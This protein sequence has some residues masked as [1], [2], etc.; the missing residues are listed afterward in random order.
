M[1]VEAPP[2]SEGG[3]ARPTR[4]VVQVPP[5]LSPGS[6]FTAEVGGQLM[7]VKVPL[8]APARTE[9]DLATGAP[10][11]SAPGHA[12]AR[13]GSARRAR[14]LRG[15]SKARC[16]SSPSEAGVESS[17]DLESSMLSSDALAS[18][19]TGSRLHSLR[20]GRLA[21]PADGG[22]PGAGGGVERALLA[23]LL[24]ERSEQRGEAGGE[25]GARSSAATQLGAQ[26]LR[27]DPSPT[28]NSST[29][30]NTSRTAPH[31]RPSPLALT[32][33]PTRCSR[34]SPRSSRTRTR[35]SGA[36]ARPRPR[37]G[38]TRT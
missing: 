23:L 29:D 24:E 7:E 2:P 13:H 33:P 30:P 36:G 34:R 35:A 9:G 25:A 31:H 17:S 22:Q 3:A 8:H 28:T 15:A 6:S 27:P 4:W 26:V 11:S 1:I 14:A 19:R 37:R 18:P 16:P 38:H 21:P 12:S 32:C 5:G 20:R 10:S